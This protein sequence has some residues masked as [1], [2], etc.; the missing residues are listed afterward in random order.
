M[1]VQEKKERNSFSNFQIPTHTCGKKSRRRGD[2]H[3]HHHHDESPSPTRPG[4]RTPDS[5]GV[6]TSRP[7]QAAGSSTWGSWYLVG[8][9]TAAAR[10]SAALK[11]THI[12][13]QSQQQPAGEAIYGG[14]VG[15]RRA[16]WLWTRATS[17]RRL[18]NTVTV[19]L[20][21]S[22]CLPN[23][24]SP[25]CARAVICHCRY[26]HNCTLIFVVLL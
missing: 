17:A 20:A 9:C 11:K 7:Q 23:Y 19:A 1:T 21:V 15:S 22:I 4:P 18:F 16:T 6:G 8:G 14:P 10:V 24:R 5:P 25:Q 2:H 3:H 26:D 13:W 12:S